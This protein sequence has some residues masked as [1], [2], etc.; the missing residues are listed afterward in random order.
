MDHVLFIQ[1]VKPEKKGE[2][3]RAH[4]EPPPE[5]VRMLRESGVER[6]IIWIQGENL[7]I[8]VMA[9]DFQKAIAHQGKTRVFQDW[10][11]RM[12]PLLSEI[13]DYSG[14]GSVVTVDKIFDLE[15]QLSKIDQRD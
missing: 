5:L 14:E 9:E 3:I 8:Y 11:L 4:R 2:Y 13:Q 1:K 10:L 7:Y 12:Q 15:E 6:E